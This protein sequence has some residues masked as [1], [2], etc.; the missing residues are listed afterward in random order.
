MDKNKNAEKNTKRSSDAQVNPVD[1]TEVGKE[2][3]KGGRPRLYSS[4]DEMLEKAEEYFTLKE[5]Q[6]KPFTI[7]GLCYFLGFEDKESFSNYVNYPEFSRTVKSIRLKIEEQ[8]NEL[9]LCGNGSATG[10]IFDLKNNHGWKDKS[11]VDNN[12]KAEITEVKRRIV[13]SNQSK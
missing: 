6:E 8:K 9:L 1:K 13:R 11:E 5:C 4:P 7:A 3:N 2:K 10:V 12:I